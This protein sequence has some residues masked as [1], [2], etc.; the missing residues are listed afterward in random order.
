MRLVYGTAGT[1]R[2]ASP[3]DGSAY[4]AMTWHVRVGVFHSMTKSGFFIPSEYELLA[5]NALR[6]KVCI[7]RYRFPEKYMFENWDF[8]EFS[9]TKYPSVFRKI[10]VAVPFELLVYSRERKQSLRNVR[11]RIIWMVVF[12]FFKD[13]KLISADDLNGRFW[14]TIARRPQDIPA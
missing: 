10:A 4:C 3:H 14:E 6:D 8:V 9:R 11:E 13:G 2:R 12:D 7:R 5:A 1:A